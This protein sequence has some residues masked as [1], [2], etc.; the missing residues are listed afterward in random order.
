MKTLPN[1]IWVLGSVLLSIPTT[2]A[3][4]FDLDGVSDGLEAD[5]LST[6]APVFKFDRDHETDDPP[7]PVDWYVRR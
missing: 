3:Q 1:L 5:L 7:L 6:F 2:P 4:D